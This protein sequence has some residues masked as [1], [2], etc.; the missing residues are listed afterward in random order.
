MNWGMG[1]G[2]RGCVGSCLRRNDGMGGGIRS[3]TLRRDWR[4]LCGAALQ[5]GERGG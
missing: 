2:M 1:S 5:S 3:A 4:K